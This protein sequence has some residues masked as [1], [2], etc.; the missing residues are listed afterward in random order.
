LCK[1]NRSSSVAHVRK[2]SITRATVKISSS[3]PR[4]PHRFGANSKD[5][6][7]ERKTERS[8][9]NSKTTCGDHAAASFEHGWRSA[10]MASSCTRLTSTGYAADTDL[11]GLSD[12]DCGNAGGKRAERVPRLIRSARRQRKLVD[13]MPP[14][15]DDR[16]NWQNRYKNLPGR[17]SSHLRGRPLES[18]RPGTFK[19][20]LG[21]N[22]G[23]FFG[24][25]PITVRC[26]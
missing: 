3:G 23:S 21:R 7:G 4:V 26:G 15:P 19:F 12:I 1:L 2:T 9:R 13:P 18:N 24:N 10:Q 8:R 11:A 5:R 22:D 16:A 14:R 20:A 17:F 6:N 25:H